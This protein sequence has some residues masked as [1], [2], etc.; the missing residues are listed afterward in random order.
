MLWFTLNTAVVTRIEGNER[1]GLT[2]GHV[3]ERAGYAPRWLYHPDQLM[4]PV[5]RGE[6]VVGTKWQ[7]IFGSRL[8]G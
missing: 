6:N 4:H 3:Y 2:L 8:S 7:R 5:K 1:H